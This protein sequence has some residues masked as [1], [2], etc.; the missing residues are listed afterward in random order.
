MQ[1]ARGPSSTTINVRGCVTTVTAGSL[2]V[3]WRTWTGRSNSMFAGTWMYRPSSRKAVFRASSASAFQ[4]KVEAQV[5]ED[6]VGRPFDG[7]CEVADGHA[8]RQIT[9]GGEAVVESAVDE[10]HA[11][12][13]CAFDEVRR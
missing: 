1:V 13:V 5:G 11:M 7:V 9:D 3:T 8:G 12:Y 4:S 2:T 10:D 6:S